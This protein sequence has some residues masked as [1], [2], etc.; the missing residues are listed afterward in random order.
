MKKE[1]QV[2][3]DCGNELDEFGDCTDCDKSFLE[4]LDEDLEWVI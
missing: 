2:C 1:I 4:L 3:P